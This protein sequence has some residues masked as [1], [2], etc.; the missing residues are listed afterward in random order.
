MLPTFVAGQVW[1]AGAGPGDPGLITVLGLHALQTADI[2][3]YDALVNRK[4]L[5]Q[6]PQARLEF[7][8]KKAGRCARTQEQINQMLVDA[9]RRNKRVLR[10][11]GGDPMVFGRG[12]EE[13]AALKA[14]GV[15]FR[16]IPGVTAA[17]AAC[18]YAG[19]PITQ[20]RYNS[21]VILATG[22]D[23]HGQLPTDINWR[24]LAE[25]KQPIVFFMSLRH[26][27][28]IS[29][30]LVAA[31]MDEDE[32][33]VIISNATLSEQ[34]VFACSVARLRECYDANEIKSPALLVIGSVTS[35]REVYDWFDASSVRGG[36]SKL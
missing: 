9:A 24:A 18:A 19:I 21:S 34:R 36:F 10:L 29:R 17:T 1:L 15:R 2:V 22:H 32:P 14:A 31:G 25:S 26:L 23:A 16:I 8:G 20:R 28:G 35:L 3:F 27:D 6:A 33:A 30:N 12:G 7:A 11:K 4:L 5:E 13:L